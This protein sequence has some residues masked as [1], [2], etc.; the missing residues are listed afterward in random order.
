MLSDPWFMLLIG[1]LC[2]WLVQLFLDKV[3]LRP[4]LLKMLD[5]KAGLV[6]KDKL[7]VRVLDQ[8][9][10]IADLTLDS[11]SEKVRLE[12]RIA[13]LELDLRMAQVVPPVEVLKTDQKPL[14][15]AEENRDSAKVY[16]KAAK[17]DRLSKIKGIGPK[18]ETLLWGAGI[19]SFSKL[20][21]LS[22]E[23]IEKIIQPESWKKLDYAEWVSAAADLAKGSEL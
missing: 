22:V 11:S 7:T 10:R 6:D 12:K 17:R 8:Q 20:A 4:R 21:A 3:Y 18:Y 16:A 2:G 1:F 19:V 13:K 14:P 9:K 5:E 15:F 23:D